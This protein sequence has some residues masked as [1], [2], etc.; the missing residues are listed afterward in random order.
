MKNK[1]EHKTEPVKQKKD[2]WVVHPTYRGSVTVRIGGQGIAKCTKEAQMQAY[3]QL[4]D[5]GTE[6]FD[7]TDDEIEE[8]KQKINDKLIIRESERDRNIRTALEKQE[9]EL[10]AA[11]KAVA[12]DFYSQTDDPNAVFG[13]KTKA[14]WG[15]K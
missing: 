3:A 7:L 8:N 9:E 11:R 5:A 4:H 2:L 10:S 1:G 14:E 13:G 15:I 12:S 6:P